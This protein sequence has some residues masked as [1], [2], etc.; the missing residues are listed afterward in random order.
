[1]HDAQCMMFRKPS[2]TLVCL[3]LSGGCLHETI[4][5]TGC[6]VDAP[7]SRHEMH[8][9]LDGHVHLSVP[10]KDCCG[11]EPVGG[12]A[13]HVLVGFLGS[14]PIE[15][16]NPQKGGAAAP[17]GKKVPLVQ[18]VRSLL[19]VYGHEELGC[20]KKLE[21]KDGHEDGTSLEGIFGG[22]EHR[23]CVL[24]LALSFVLVYFAIPMTGIMCH[25]KSCD[26]KAAFNAALKAVA[27]KSSQ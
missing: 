27:K 26:F 4:D 14:I 2:S 13:H 10:G 23:A 15:S 12:G 9:H 16:D 7:K 19:E 22:E 5:V 24:C 25:S 3:A 18:F 8:R 20:E 1:M 11:Q 6:K 17:H 21:A